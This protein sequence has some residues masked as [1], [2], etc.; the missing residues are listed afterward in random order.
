MSIT[1][2]AKER[3]RR[4]ALAGQAHTQV[5]RILPVEDADESSLMLGYGGFFLQITFSEL[6]PL[7]AICLARSLNRPCTAKDMRH[8]ND[9]NLITAF[10]NHSVNTEAGCYSYKT[11]HWLDT[12]LTEERF[13][14]ILSRSVDIAGR[15][16]AKLAHETGGAA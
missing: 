12:E 4:K 5:A 2:N 11:A 14:E 6:H 7:I 8:V 3:A 10:G 16:Y 13:M 1:I 9:F 15:V